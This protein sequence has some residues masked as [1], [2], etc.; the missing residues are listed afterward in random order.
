MSE[1]LRLVPPNFLRVNVLAIDAAEFLPD[2]RKI[3]PAAQIALL[4]KKISPAQKKICD[5]VRADVFVG[6]C[7]TLPAEDKIFELIIAPKILAAGKNF[8]ATLLTLNRLLTDSG[9]LLAEFPDEILTRRD[10]VKLLDDA[11]FKEII[12]SGGFV[13]AC[14]CS[15]EVAALKEFFT[16][17]IRAEL[18]RLLH[19]I[20]YG[21]DAEKNFFRLAEICRREKIFVEYLTDFVEQVVVHSA[22]K[23]LLLEQIQTLEFGLDD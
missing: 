5:D 10:A 7:Q 23:K 14:R 17:E 21:I 4:T 16:P 3:L 22:A 8:Y 19:R 15:A 1:I 9:A 12:F 13:K 6:D 2:L 20:E 11:L 18:A